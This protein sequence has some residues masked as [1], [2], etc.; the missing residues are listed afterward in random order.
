MNRVGETNIS[1]EGCKLTI[2]NYN[3]NRDVDI[4]IEGGI[5][6]IIVKN[7][8]VNFLSGEIK[9]PYFPKQCGVGYLG[10]GKYKSRV[11]K[12]LTIEYCTWRSMIRRCYSDS[13][14]L[15]QPTYKD[16]TVDESWHN[17]QV[18][19][20]WFY[21]NYKEGFQLDKDILIKGNKIYSPETCCF[22]PTRINTI[23]KKIGGNNIGVRKRYKLYECSIM[24]ESKNIKVGNFN[25]IEEANKARKEV[26]EKYIKE[27]AEEFKHLINSRVY[28]AMCNWSI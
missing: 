9:N 21:E 14:H 17:F 2:I 18:F 4:L 7:R 24:I 12:E 23:F 25:T 5:K 15:K 1:N 27:V 6:N 19:A 11:N 20:E 26:K 16:C 3:N 13:F 10:E 28:E 8:L 22:V